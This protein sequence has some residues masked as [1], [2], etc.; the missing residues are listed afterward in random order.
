[1]RQ[2]LRVARLHAFGA[3]HRDCALTPLQQGAA[4][5]GGLLLC[6]MLRLLVPQRSRG[7]EAVLNSVDEHLGAGFGFPQSRASCGSASLVARLLILG[8]V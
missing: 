7:H 5:A 2:D 3:R 4:W 1:M 6:Y 8:R